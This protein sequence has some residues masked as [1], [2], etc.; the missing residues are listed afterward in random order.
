MNIRD[1]HMDTKWTITKWNKEKS[2]FLPSEVIG[3][4]ILMQSEINGASLWLLAWLMPAHRA[5]HVAKTTW[6]AS[7]PPKPHADTVFPMNSLIVSFPKSCRLQ[8]PG[9]MFPGCGLWTRPRGQEGREIYR[10]GLASPLGDAIGSNIWP[11][12]LSVNCSW[13][14]CCLVAKQRARERELYRKWERERGGW[15][16]GGEAS[17]GSL[18]LFFS[19]FCSNNCSVY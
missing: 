16:G 7:C 8:P 18:V 10:G 19:L 3:E 15:G 9:P 12:G 1:P 2:V 4:K 17:T 5:V 14:L 6:P 13:P 11:V